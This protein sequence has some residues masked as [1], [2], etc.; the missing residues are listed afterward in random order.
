MQP[1]NS[2]ACVVVPIIIYLN[3]VKLIVILLSVVMLSAAKAE[4]YYVDNSL[5]NVIQ[6][7]VTVLTIVG[8]M[9]IREV[10]L[11]KQ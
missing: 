5:L 1:F 11:R 6:L 9:S 2:T 7:N 4:H 10:S 3:A 8:S